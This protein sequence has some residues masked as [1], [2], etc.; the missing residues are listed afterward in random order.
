MRA[1]GPSDCSEGRTRDSQSKGREHMLQ[2]RLR[3]RPV[4]RFLSLLLI[5]ALYVE[6]QQPFFYCRLVTVSLLW[7]RVMHLGNERR[8]VKHILSGGEWE[9]LGLQA[10]FL[11]TITV[12]TL[13]N[14]FSVV[15]GCSGTEEKHSGENEKDKK[16]IWLWSKRGPPFFN[17]IKH[18]VQVQKMP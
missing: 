16:K 3:S 13:Q 11:Y 5:H 18:E 2:W 4:L 15:Q 6:Q 14:N 9:E 17:K 10:E 1:A 8:A 12:R 7:Y